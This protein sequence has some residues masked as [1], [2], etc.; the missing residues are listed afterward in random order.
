MFLKPSFNSILSLDIPILCVDY[1]L[2]PESPFPEAL[3]EVLDIYL[4]LVSKHPSVKAKLG[5]YPDKIAVVG[6]SAGGNLTVSLS[7]V[8]DLIQKHLNQ[9]SEAENSIRMPHSLYCFY[10]P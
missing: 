6:D 3:Q 7:I 9:L 4:W 2:S 10:A 8:L 5:Y 1:S